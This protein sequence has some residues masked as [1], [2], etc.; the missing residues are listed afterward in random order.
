LVQIKLLAGRS[1]DVTR[2][3]IAAGDTQTEK[4]LP[5]INLI[6][7]RSTTRALGFATPEA[8]VGREITRRFASGQPSER[9]IR[10]IGVVEDNMYG[11][12]HRIPGPQI[13]PLMLTPEVYSLMLNYEA[14]A[15]T[16][17]PA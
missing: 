2:D 12:L 8:A 15:E 13:Y 16:A 3:R 14:S 4:P 17:L 6:A 5:V 10:I 1:Y 11:S 7:N 9:P